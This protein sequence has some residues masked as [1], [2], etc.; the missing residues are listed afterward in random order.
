MR[1]AFIQMV[2]VLVEDFLVLLL[3]CL[4]EVNEACCTGKWGNFVKL[5]LTLIESRHNRKTVDCGDPHCVDESLIR[6][7][8]I[9][10]RHEQRERRASAVDCHT[11]SDSHQRADLS[12]D[13][14]DLITFES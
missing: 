5:D 13:G 14:T 9:H 3:L 12:G 6:G 11:G 1:P 7:T 10:R 2:H 8:Q 4:S